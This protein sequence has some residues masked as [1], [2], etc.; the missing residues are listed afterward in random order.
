MEGIYDDLAVIR[1]T[2]LA[3]P[4]RFYDSLYSEFQQTLAA[5]TSPTASAVDVQVGRMKNLLRDASLLFL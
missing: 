4:P 3:A 1:P 5:R 2:Y